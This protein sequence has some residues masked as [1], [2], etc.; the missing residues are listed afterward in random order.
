MPASQTTYLSTHPNGR[1]GQ[2]ADIT[3]YDADSMIV[4]ETNGIGFGLSCKRGTDDDE[5]LVGVADN[6]FAG[7]SVLDPTRDPT[8]DDLYATG[9]H[10][11]IMT[12]GDVFIQVEYEVG[13]G[14]QA[15]ADAVSG[16]LSADGVSAAWAQGD[17]Y[18]VGDHVT[19]GNSEYRCTRAHTAL[20]G[21]VAD[22]APDQAAATG[23]EAAGGK[24][25]KVP[26][27][28][29]HTSAATGGLAVL[30]LG[31]LPRS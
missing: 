19:Q 14:D 7:I 2:I 10:A 21:D 3:S 17:A 29:W 4:E 6:N 1:P 5:V 30:R 8:Q 13:K 23:W 28:V 31:G 24:Q 12:R 18:V 16:A 22:G 15:T 26:G 11:T 9:A 27:A 25:L 20:A